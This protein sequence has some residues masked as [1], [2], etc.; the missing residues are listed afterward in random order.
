MKN[1][2][3]AS[4]LPFFPLSVFF[5]FLSL[6][7]AA[8]SLT[9]SHPTSY[10]TSPNHPCERRCREKQGEREALPSSSFLPTFCREE[11]EV[12]ASKGSWL[13]CLVGLASLLPSQTGERKEGLEGRKTSALPLSL[14]NNKTAL[15]A[16]PLSF[17][18]FP[19]LALSEVYISERPSK[20]GEKKFSI[21]SETP[22]GIDLIPK[23]ERVPLFEI[24]IPASLDSSEHLISSQKDERCHQ[25]LFSG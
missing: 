11:E 2:R 4:P 8:H 3:V 19:H 13:A 12:V 20:N 6:S 16:L 24:V 14:P 15:P 21:R 5:R 22:S 25:L 7:L 23:G 10:I 17:F 9:S 18:S 1:P